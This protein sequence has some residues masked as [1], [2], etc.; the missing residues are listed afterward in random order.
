MT[1][2]NILQL[3]FA[4][5][6]C[7]GTPSLHARSQSTSGNQTMDH[8]QIQSTIDINNV[9]VAAGDMQRILA[10]YEPEAVLMGQHGMP[11]KGTSALR[12]A[13]AQFLVLQPKI[14]ILNQDIVQADDIALHAYTWKMNGK[15]PDGNPVEQSGVSTVVLRKQPDGRWLMVIDNPFAGQLLRN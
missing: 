1:F 15:T 14:T 2:R 4:A 5:I 6:L 7:V 12:E 3:T 13:F 11:A 10:T 9:A 8:A